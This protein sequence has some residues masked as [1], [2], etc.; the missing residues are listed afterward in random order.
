ML[1]KLKQSVF[2]NYRVVYATPYCYEHWIYLFCH[3]KL[4][5]I[6]L[7]V[8]EQVRNW[9]CTPP[10]TWNHH[11]SLCHVSL[12]SQEINST[13]RTGILISIN[14]AFVLQGNFKVSSE[15]F[16]SIINGVL[17]IFSIIIIEEWIAIIILLV[18]LLFTLTLHRLE[19]LLSKYIS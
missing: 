1:F 16:I 12:I 14:H 4:Q 3:Y 18:L 8:C 9:Q 7:W 19:L 17:G 11:R 6:H 10:V 5:I 15:A 2:L 13:N